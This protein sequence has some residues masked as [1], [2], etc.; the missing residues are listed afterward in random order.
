MMFVVRNGRDFCP[1]RLPLDIKDRSIATKLLTGSDSLVGGHEHSGPSKQFELTQVQ[2]TSLLTAYW[3]DVETR[4]TR[5]PLI[6]DPL[7]QLLVEAL[8][9]P[10]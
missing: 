3:R 5:N 7:A 4:Q 8:L 10:S 1:Q 2:S 9:S 6:S